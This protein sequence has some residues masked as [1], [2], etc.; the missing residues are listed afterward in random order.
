MKT[1]TRTTQDWQAEAFYRVVAKVYRQALREA[2]RGRI[3]AIGWLDIV[4]PDWR[5]LQQKSV[6]RALSRKYSS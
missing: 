5:T 1:Q 3:D 2:Q 6:R 4:A